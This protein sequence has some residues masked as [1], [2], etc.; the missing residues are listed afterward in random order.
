MICLHQH[1]GVTC[2]GG[3]QRHWFDWDWLVSNRTLWFDPMVGSVSIGKH[4]PLGSELEPNEC[5]HLLAVV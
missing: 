2:F 5:L 1:D 4:G 3:K